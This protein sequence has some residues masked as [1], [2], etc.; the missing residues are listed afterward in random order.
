MVRRTDTVALELAATGNRLERLWEFSNPEP[1]I[2]GL[3]WLGFVIK[4]NLLT[5]VELQPACDA[6]DENLCEQEGFSSRLTALERQFPHASVL[7]HTEGILHPNI[8]Q[9]WANP[10]LLDIA[11]QVLGGDFA[12]HP[13]WNLRCKVVRGGHRTGLAGQHTCCVGGTWYIDLPEEQMTSVLQCDLDA[14]VVTCEVAK[15]SVLLLNNLVPHRSLNNLSDHIRWS[16]DLR[17]QQTGLPNGFYGIKESLPMRADGNRAYPIAWDGW[18]QQDRQVAQR[19]QVGPNAREAIAEVTDNLETTVVGPWMN[20]YDHQAYA[21]TTELVYGESFE[22]FNLPSAAPAMRA[23]A[24]L[25]KTVADPRGINNG[26]QTLYW[27]QVQGTSDQLLNITDHPFNGLQALRLHASNTSGPVAISNRGFKGQG[28]DL[29]ANHDYEGLVYAR[30]S[31]PTLVSVSLEDFHAGRVLALATLSIQGTGNWEAL[32][33]RLV[34]NSDT[35]CFDYPW[36]Q[37]P[38]YCYPGLQDRIGHAC[39]QCGGQLVFRLLQGQV[40]LDMASLQPGSWGRFAPE[41]RVRRDI[42]EHLLAMGVDG[43][44][45]GGTYVKTDV[46]LANSSEIGYYWKALRGAPSSRPP[47]VQMGSGISNFWNPQLRSAV[48]GPFE[49]LNLTEQLNM[50]ATI[51]LNHLESAA[52]L[53]DLVSYMFATNASDAMA[54][55]RQQDGHPEPYNLD[56]FFELGNE[57]LNTNYVSQVAEMEGRAKSLNL[58]KKL[59]YACPWECLNDI[60]RN[61]AKQYGAQ[62]YLDRHDADDP[63]ASTFDPIIAQWEAEGIDARFTIW[64][65]NTGTLHDM[66][67]A[68]Q[69]A[70]DMNQYERRGSAS[71]RLDSRTASF[72]VEASGH[73]DLWADQHG[74]QGLIFFAPNQTWAQPPYHV[75]AMIQDTALPWVLSVPD[76]SSTGIDLAAL[77]SDDKRQVTT[78]LVN[79]EATPLSVVLDVRGHTG[80]RV[81]AET[82]QL[83][84]P[85][86]DLD[87]ANPAWQPDLITPKLDVVS[88]V[89][90]QDVWE[91]PPFSFMTITFHLE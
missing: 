67:R 64:E 74:D 12:A 71:L 47:I 38:L 62:V 3:R 55:L 1:G 90:G 37:P 36:G 42:V 5:D 29:K 76:P 72:C 30:A 39:W 6:I 89:L 11:Q 85:S 41:Q 80:Q 45:L 20:R 54:Q 13:V 24:D 49:L 19:A 66:R 84:A 78:R 14:D 40:D 57:I 10:K 65:T 18:A 22:S 73:D 15:G 31:V 81:Q 51:T 46:A 52:D 53:A 32:A 4:E 48:F 60:F 26:N 68:L 50:T 58:G 61:G 82:R 63:Q 91:I 9:L 88:I 7:L 35:A 59:R 16:F 44:R 79:F 23:F 75:H 70:Q 25:D 33:F 87:A 27:F 8:Q 86:G 83:S 56:K 28:L 77:V 34:S 43:I 17:W 69:E 2:D 21:F